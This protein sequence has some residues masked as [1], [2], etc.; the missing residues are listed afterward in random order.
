MIESLSEIVKNEAFFKYEEHD[1]GHLL[2]DDPFGENDV[3]YVTFHGTDAQGGIIPT[4]TIPIDVQ[5]SISPKR[6]FWWIV[7]KVRKLLR[8]KRSEPVT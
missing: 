3:L 4:T 2:W 1:K 5:E 8:G 7:G 6:V